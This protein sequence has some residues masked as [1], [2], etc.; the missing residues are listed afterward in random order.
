MRTIVLDQYVNRPQFK[1][2]TTEILG[3]YPAYT[4]RKVTATCGCVWVGLI[5]TVGAG[6]SDGQ[7]RLCPSHTIPDDGDGDDN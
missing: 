7:I 1:G 2:A 6:V 3:V 4:R 5:G